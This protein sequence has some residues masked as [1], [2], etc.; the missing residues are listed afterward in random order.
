MNP[1]TEAKQLVTV[2]V[3]AAACDVTIGAVNKWE[4]NGMP[5][6]EFSKETNYSSI[7]SSLTNRKVT[8]SRL[9]SWTLELRENRAA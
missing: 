4:K 6:T 5:R 1:I 2:K 9:L 8:K 7:I 3:V